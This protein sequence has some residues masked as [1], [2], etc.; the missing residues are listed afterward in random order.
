MGSG[1]IKPEQVHSNDPAVTRLLDSA[2]RGTSASNRPRA[3]EW[4]TL[5][6]NLRQQLVLADR[7]VLQM[8]PIVTRP[9]KNLIESFVPKR[10]ILKLN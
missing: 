6:T 5:L 2:R 3:S 8:P 4:L 7:P 10:P 1:I 9:P